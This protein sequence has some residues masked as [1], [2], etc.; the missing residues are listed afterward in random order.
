MASIHNV[1]RPNNAICWQNIFNFNTDNGLLP[2]GVRSLIDTM[3]TL[4][5]D[6]HIIYMLKNNISQYRIVLVISWKY[7]I[8][9]S[10]IKHHYM[11]LIALRRD[12]ATTWWCHHC[13]RWQFV[14][15]GNKILREPMLTQ[16]NV[17]TRPQWVNDPIQT[18][19]IQ[20]LSNPNHWAKPIT[21]FK[22]NIGQY[23]IVLVIFWK[24]VINQTKIK[25]QSMMWNA[26]RWDKATT[27]W[28]HHCARWHDFTWAYVDPS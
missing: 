24:Y 2:V 15:S 4:F 27:W 12:K 7:V 21:K 22:N 1:L 11:M 25:H 19:N 18:E 13:A 10:K 6:L 14:P 9:Q 20:M 17:T 23:H 28:C 16:V 26:L 8:N 5:R 3:S